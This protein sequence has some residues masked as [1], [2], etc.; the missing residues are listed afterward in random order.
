MA[1]E[2]AF[3]MRVKKAGRL[4]VMRKKDLNSREAA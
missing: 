3:R 4:V 1:T 2:E